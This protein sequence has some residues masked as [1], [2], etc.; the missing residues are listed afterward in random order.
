MIA[1]MF[2]KEYIE[3]V[4]KYKLVILASVILFFA[5]A[6]PILVKLLPAIVGSQ[7]PE[8]FLEA[9]VFTP[10]DGLFNFVKNV[11]QIILIVFIFTLSGL[12]GGE[13]ANQQILIPMT[14]GYSAKKSLWIKFLY[15][16]VFTLM[17]MLAG[18]LINMLYN[19]ILFEG[20]ALT[21]AEVLLSWTAVS[22][23]MIHILS[24]VILLGTLIRNPVVTGFLVLII[25]F[26]EL[27]FSQLLPFLPAAVQDTDI[28]GFWFIWSFVILLTFA[29]LLLSGKMI[30][31]KKISLR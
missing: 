25:H 12:S 22:V 20:R 30:G 21:I 16:S 1:A 2:W 6:D 5:I 18:I 13:F 31:Y 28:S 9:F 17:I 15:Y 29:I 11:N 27:G 7:L 23:Y 24:L 8:G 3:S 4:R 14:K 19:N 26:L 10:E